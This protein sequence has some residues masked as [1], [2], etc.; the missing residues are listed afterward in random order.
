MIFTK[1]I[2]FL[3]I[4]W[5]VSVNW[6]ILRDRPR[7]LPRISYFNKPGNA[8]FLRTR[9]RTS[10]YSQEIRK[11]ASR[12]FAE[13]TLVASNSSYLFIY[14]SIYLLFYFSN[15]LY[16]SCDFSSAFN[17]FFDFYFDPGFLYLLRE[18]FRIPYQF[19]T[20]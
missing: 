14:L 13:H 18:V 11:V 17:Y 19:C 4:Y 15:F 1:K 16:S 12:I 20:R 6:K 2:F 7:I 5:K 3:N 9:P 10:Y 8:A